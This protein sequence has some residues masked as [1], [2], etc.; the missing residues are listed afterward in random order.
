MDSVCRVFSNHALQW[1]VRL[2][3]CSAIGSAR[4]HAVTCSMRADLPYIDDIFEQH[5]PKGL[6]AFSRQQPPKTKAIYLLLR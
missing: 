6:P 5:Q 3:K 2:E 1:Q 4:L